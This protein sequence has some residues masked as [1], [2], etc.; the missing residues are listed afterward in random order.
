MIIDPEK[1]RGN[2]MCLAACPYENV[3]YFNDALNIAQKCT[4]CA[5]LLDDGW[6]EPRCVDAC[7]TGAFTFGDE[8]DP[9]IKA[10]I[11]K[12]EPLKP[13]LAQREAAG[14]LHRSAQ[15]V[16]RRSRVRQEGRP[17]RRGRDCHRHQRRDRREGHRP[18]PTATATS[19]CAVSRTASTRCSI[20][21]PG[22][23]PEKLGPV[24]VTQ[25]DLNVG[26]IALKKA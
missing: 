1:C 12:A 19:G 13:E 3:I 14:L 10:L 26:D 4:F 8:N 25:K 21:K 24:D 9:K 7:P 2:Q 15:E 18:P 11:A 5:H 23:K 6:S 17:V 20:E 22:Y 16:H